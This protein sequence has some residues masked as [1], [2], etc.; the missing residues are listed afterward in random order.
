MA[1]W[2]N[3]EFNRTYLVNNLPENWEIDDVG[4]DDMIEVM[5]ESDREDIRLW[6]ID[7]HRNFSER[8]S[9]RLMKLRECYLE[10]DTHERVLWDLYFQQMMSLRDIGKKLDL[11]HMSIYSMINELKKKIKEWIGIE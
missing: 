1:K 8:D 5:C 6:M 9:E 7:L 4:E 10:L 3:S 11:P 2:S